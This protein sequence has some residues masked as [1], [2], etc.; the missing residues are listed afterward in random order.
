MNRRSFHRLA[1]SEVLLR[2]LFRVSTKTFDKRWNLGVITDQVDLNLGHVLKSFCSKYELGWAE[3]RYLDLD[4]KK[5]YVYADTKPTE[6]KQ[7]RH[8]LDDAGVK[9]SVLDTAIFK[10]TLPGTTPAA[11]SLRRCSRRFEVWA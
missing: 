3:I 4:G 1:A 10:I 5:T 2:P 11:A 6:L 8:Q 9:L 7:I